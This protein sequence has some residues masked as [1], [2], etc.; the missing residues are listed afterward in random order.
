[1]SKTDVVII[2]CF[3]TYEQRVRLLERF[4]VE[5]GKSVRVI[6]SDWEHFK[7]TVRK[8]C[9]E[10]YE[11]LHV[12][13]YMKNLSAD[14]LRSHY[15]FAKKALERARELQPELLW[16][17]V[18]P[19]ALVKFAAAYKYEFPGVKLI[20][21]LIDMW[22]ETMPI[23]KVKAL[24]PF[25]FWRNL[26]DRNLKAADAVVTECG[27]YQTILGK[28]CEADK[29]YTLYLARERTLPESRPNP[30]TDRTSLCYLGSINNIIDIPRI[31]QIIRDIGGAVELHIVGD[32]EK[33]QELIDTAKSAG[34]QVIYHGKV[35]DAAKKQEIFDSCHYG[36]NV[37]KETVFVGLTMK[38]MDYF[39]AGLP[40]INTIKGD[41]WEMVTKYGLGINFDNSVEIDREISNKESQRNRIR[42]FFEQNLTY[43][44]FAENV[45]NILRSCN[46]IEKSHF[47]EEMK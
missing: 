25:S 46:A 39:E 11:L 26:R 19:N 41:T 2:N 43:D 1:M 32:G 22:P 40:I 27:L 9:P 13:P 6:T 23:A 47:T 20:F 12:R 4:F 24:P 42:D 7:K 31:G 21:D 5:A 45:E 29:M 33:R 35:Y 10:N 3:E 34:A 36:L 38:S 17:L 16:I 15:D 44:R 14:R 8:E 28:V 37:M 18:P 30:P